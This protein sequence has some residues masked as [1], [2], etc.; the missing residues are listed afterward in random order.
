MTCIGKN[1]EKHDRDHKAS[2]VFKAVTEI[3]AL[4][5]AVRGFL[6]T[7]GMRSDLGCLQ[8]GLQVLPAVQGIK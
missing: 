3:P 7:Y 6:R 1:D 8:T 2:S 5:S 4:Y